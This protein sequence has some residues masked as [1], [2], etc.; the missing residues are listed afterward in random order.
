MD[1]MDSTL[2]YMKHIP[3]DCISPKNIMR[4]DEKW[5]LSGLALI[6]GLDK[7]LPEYNTTNSDQEKQVVFSWACLL[8]KLVFGFTPFP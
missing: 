4:M 7:D 6:F 2:D 1:V 3:Y 5:Y 8:F